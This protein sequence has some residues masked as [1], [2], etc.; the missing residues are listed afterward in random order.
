MTREAA[1]RIGPFEYSDEQIPPFITKGPIDMENGIRYIG[2]FS[3][4]MRNGKGKQVWQDYT[5]YEGF[6]EDD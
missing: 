5:L 4:G 1:T 3:N 6:W 2:Q